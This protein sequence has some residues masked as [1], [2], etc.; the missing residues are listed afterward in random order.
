VGA[1]RVTNRLAALFRA[2]YFQPELREGKDSSIPPTQEIFND[3]TAPGLDDQPN[4]FRFASQ[5]FYDYRDIA[6]NPNRGGLL[7]FTYARAFD[8]S[9]ED[10]FSFY[11]V[12]FDARQY[13]PLWSEQRMLAFRFYT[14]FDQPVDNG[15]VPFYLM[16]TLG[17]SDSL[18]GYPD[19]R[20]RDKNLLLLSAE[21]RWEPAPPVE[22]VLFYDTG[23]VFPESSEFGFS[24]LKYGYGFGIRLKTETSVQVRFD[25]GHSEEGTH[26]YLKWV[27]SF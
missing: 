5:V 26:Y 15:V 18:R 22:L 19:F 13:F 12:A 14:S 25:I 24:D 4:Y 9:D 20:F 7:A 10:E 11:R 27:A 8:L 21:Y 16:Q 3:I 2:G 17:G 1:F 23:K 6:G